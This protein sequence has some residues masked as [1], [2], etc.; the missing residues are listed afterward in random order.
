ME[1]IKS[2]TDFCERIANEAVN[3]KCVESLIKAGCI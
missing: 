1:N 2:F 3:K